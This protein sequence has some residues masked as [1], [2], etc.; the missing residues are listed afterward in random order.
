VFLIFLLRAVAVSPAL[1]RLLDNGN[2]TLFT[3]MSGFALWQMLAFLRTQSVK[4]LWLGSLFLDL[5]ALSRNKGPV[6][7]LIDLGIAFV[8]CLR[9]GVVKK[10][11]RGVS[12]AVHRS[13]GRLCAPV[14]V[15]DGAVWM[16]NQ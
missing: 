2:N 4:H 14:W 13:G 12:D 8:A 16:A 7:F 6:L 5:A 11:D 15:A 9:A 10:G 1:T 3:A